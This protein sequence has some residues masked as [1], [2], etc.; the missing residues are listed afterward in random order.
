MRLLFLQKL[1]IIL[2]L[3]Y[4]SFFW[5]LW[6][7]PDNKWRHTTW[8]AA[9]CL[10]SHFLKKESLIFVFQPFSREVGFGEGS[11]VS[12]SLTA[13]CWILK[14]LWVS[15]ENTCWLLLLPSIFWVSGYWESFSV[16]GRECVQVRWTWILMNFNFAV[17]STCMCPCFSFLGWSSVASILL[18]FAAFEMLKLLVVFFLIGILVFLS[19]WLTL[20]LLKLLD[21]V[22]NKY[23]CF[24]ISLFS[25]NWFLKLDR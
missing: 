9:L 22:R 11:H 7:Q 21:F 2:C 12:T 1:S 10:R 8:W 20:Q 23:L 13:S 15:L 25:F 24:D 19:S 16:S 18:Q 6:L 17:S 5:H 4:F 3:P 14:V